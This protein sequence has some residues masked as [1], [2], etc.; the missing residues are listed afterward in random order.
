MSLIS[1]RRALITHSVAAAAPGSDFIGANVQISG[2]SPISFP[3]GTVAGDIAM[4]TMLGNASP[5]LSTGT[6]IVNNATIGSNT[7]GYVVTVW[8]KVLTAGDISSPPTYSGNA[9]QTLVW[10]GGS[11]IALKVGPTT[12]AGSGTTV[13]VTGFTK[14][15]GSRLVIATAYDRDL[16][17]LPNK[18]ADSGFTVPTTAIGAGP[19]KLLA[20][21]TNPN[22]VNGTAVT[23]SNMDSVTDDNS[24]ALFEIT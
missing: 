15:G 11:A 3:A 14:A 12:G 18:T 2:G 10:R 13:S 1:T 9:I 6:K 5:T 22:Y 19:D 21:A 23:W 4:F 7:F 8:Y 16:N 20:V 24:A 17:G